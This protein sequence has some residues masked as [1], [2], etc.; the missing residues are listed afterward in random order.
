MNTGSIQELDAWLREDGWGEVHSYWSALPQTPVRAVLKI[1]SP[2]VLA[3]L[4]WFE[5]VF[6]RVDPSVGAKLEFL[7]NYEGKYFPEK[8]EITFPQP[9]SWSTAISSERLALN[10]IHRASS[11]ATATREL[12]EI[13]RPHGIQILDTRKT[14]PGLRELEKYAVRVGGGANHRFTQTD[15]F[16]I[17]DNHKELMGLKGAVEFFK[18]LNQPYK[19]LITEI[20]SLSDLE[21]A[22]SLGLR[23]FMLDNFSSR[24]LSEACVSKRHGEFFEVSGGINKTTISKFLVKG[25]DAL[26]V[27]KITQFPDA[28]DISFKFKPE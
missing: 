5:A 14:T 22:R 27:G 9:L 4:E 26:S 3:G 10:L 7:K 24:D 6:K 15:C 1:K 8:M 16:M 11:V 13:A 18:N 25:V 20:H 23:F 17:K 19:T 2:M 21:T 12:V 28:V